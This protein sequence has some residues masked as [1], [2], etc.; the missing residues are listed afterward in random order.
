MELTTERLLL[1]PFR[2][3]DAAAVYEYCSDP[4]VGEA[5]GW[6]PHRSVEESLEI[7]RTVFASP[8][9]FALVERESGRLI[10]SAGFTGRGRNAGGR[11]DELGYSL[12]PAFWG[13]GLMPEACGALL[14]YGFEEMGLD[15]IWCTHYEENHRS[16]RVIEKCGFQYA[17]RE[18][19]EDDMGR[20]LVR[21][22]L[23]TRETWRK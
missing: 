4:R 16:R 21:F 13:R 10:G 5:A 12:H 7:I 17:F 3:E 6:P 20:H 19:V 8:H 23:L 9:V 15:T 18:W 14:A 2:E 11:D 1:R 22:Y